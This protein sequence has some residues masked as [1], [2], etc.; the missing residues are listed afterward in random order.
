MPPDR[1]IGSILF[2]SCLFVVSLSVVNFFTYIFFIKTT[3]SNSKIHEPIFLFHLILLFGHL[4]EKLLKKRK[5]VQKLLII[6]AE[7]HIYI[8]IYIYNIRAKLRFFSN[9]YIVKVLNEYL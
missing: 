4:G 5:S 6:F 7:R 8:Y 9:I 2:L 3:Y 1:M